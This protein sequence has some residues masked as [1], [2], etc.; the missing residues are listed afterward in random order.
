M[1]LTYDGISIRM[2]VLCYGVLHRD[3]YRNGP[4]MKCDG[5]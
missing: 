5:L 3:S 2:P 4:G 1:L